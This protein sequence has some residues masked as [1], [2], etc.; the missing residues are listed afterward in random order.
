M[1][2]SGL[3]LS[4]IILIIFFSC[5]EQVKIT[6][7]GYVDSTEYVDS[8]PVFTDMPKSDSDFSKESECLILSIDNP[9]VYKV[10]ELEIGYTLTFGFTRIRVWDDDNTKNYKYELYATYNNVSYYLGEGEDIYIPDSFPFNFS[11]TYAISL[12]NLILGLP[13]CKYMSGS[14]AYRCDLICDSDN[15]WKS[16][17]TVKYKFSGF[18]QAKTIPGN[19]SNDEGFIAPKVLKI[20]NNDG[21]YTYKMWVTSYKKSYYSSAEYAAYGYTYFKYVYEVKSYSSSDGVI[22]W[23]LDNYTDQSAYCSIFNDSD[24]S[25]GGIILSDIKTVS[26]G[27]YTVYYALYL[28]K[29]SPGDTD[30]GWKL[31]SAYAYDLPKNWILSGS[32][33]R[34]KILDS[35]ASGFDNYSLGICSLNIEKP[36]Y[37]L[38]YSGSTTTKTKIGYAIN[39]DALSIF[40]KSALNPVYKG[41]TGQFDFKDVMDPCIIKEGNIYKM[42]YSGYDEAVYYLGLAYSYDGIYFSYYDSGTYLP[43]LNSS[44]GVRYPCVIE[45]EDSKGKKFKRLYFSEISS[46]K[47]HYIDSN[48]TVVSGVDTY[49]WSIKYK[50]SSSY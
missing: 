34:M 14:T 21:S 40:T 27:D 48:N 13:E 5:S 10:P 29:D 47:G 11:T 15:Y 30:S 2:K 20:K 22:G 32:S 42:Y 16:T 19:F 23:T 17:Y 35:T 36:Y 33:S 4:C 25:S 12:N 1:K 39:N 49:I 6:N 31:Y 26:E 37:K 45:D 7:N 18:L 9:E 24:S 44:Y 50:R 41:T 3:I 8:N 43:I 28:K 38:W 46:A